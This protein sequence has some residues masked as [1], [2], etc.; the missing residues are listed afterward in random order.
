MATTSSES[1]INLILNQPS[2]WIQWF[3]IIQDIAKT[4]KV[5]KYID[6]STKKDDLPALEPPKRPTPKNVLPTA[7]SIAELD[8]IQLTAYN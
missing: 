4:N 1:K 3:F 2:D 8:Q 7:I 5:W 6:P